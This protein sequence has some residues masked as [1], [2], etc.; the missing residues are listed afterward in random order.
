MIHPRLPPPG[1]SIP[2]TAQTDAVQS[3]SRELLCK[4]AQALSDAELESNADARFKVKADEVMA[5]Q[6]GERG[7]MLTLQA[8][9]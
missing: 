3:T 1:V 9:R 4:E 7:R 8:A 5:A 6:L 2:E